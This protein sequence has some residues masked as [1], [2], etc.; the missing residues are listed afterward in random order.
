MRKT[1]WESNG[2]YQYIADK[3]GNNMPNWGYTENPYMNIYIAACH[4]YYDCYNNG[5]CNYDVYANDY[6]EMLPVFLR[7]EFSF[8]RKEG[9]NPKMLKKL[10]DD[11]NYAEM[12]MDRVLEY[13]CEKNCSYEQYVMYF[14]NEQGLLS[15]KEVEGWSKITFGLEQ[16]REEWV[17][18][19]IKN[20]GDKV[21]E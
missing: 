13:L 8:V 12:F 1:Y 9:V 17:R 16:E 5:G 20:L 21:V 7:K 15:Y 2:K 4:F 18:A 3:I 6:E 10:C 19:R 14:N 11:E